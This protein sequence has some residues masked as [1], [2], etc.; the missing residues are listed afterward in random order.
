MA[1][2]KAPLPFFPAQLNSSEEVA[3]GSSRA[4]TSASAPAARF[5]AT[6]IA[7]RSPQAER[8]QKEK[9][10]RECS[11]NRARRVDPVEARQAR[12]QLRRIPREPAHQHGQR[13]AHQKCR[14]EQDQRRP[15]KSQRQQSAGIPASV[16]IRGHVD[17]ADCRQV[18]REKLRQLRQRQIPAIRRARSAGPSARSRR[19]IHALPEASPAMNTARTV[20]TAYAVWPKINPS[21]L[22][23]TT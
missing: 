10:R 21:A 19:P 16:G 20:A 7:K 22:L 8:R 14:Q 4:R 12:S 15:R 1:R 6:A 2:K 13:A 18:P 9:S 23:H 11:G 17:R 3:A 5:S